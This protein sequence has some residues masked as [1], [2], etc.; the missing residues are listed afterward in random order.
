MVFPSGIP[1]S[2]QGLDSDVDGCEILLVFD[3]GN[4]SEDSTFLL[5]DWRGP[6]AA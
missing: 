6:H 4:F 2:I 5:I 3:N 1:H